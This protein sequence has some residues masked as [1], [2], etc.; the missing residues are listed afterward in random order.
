[1]ECC[2]TDTEAIGHRYD[3]YSEQMRLLLATDVVFEPH[4]SSISSPKMVFKEQTD[5]LFPSNTS[6]FYAGWDNNKEEGVRE[7]RE[8][9]SF[10]IREPLKDVFLL[11]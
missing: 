4:K 7:N 10:C 2:R 11:H 3:S 9:L 1:M 5:R 8:L 6:A